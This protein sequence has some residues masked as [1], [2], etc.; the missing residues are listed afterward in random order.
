[1][2]KSEVIFFAIFLFVV[3]FSQFRSV[4]QALDEAKALNISQIVWVTHAQFLNLQQLC[5]TP[6][7]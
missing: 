2:L 7:R 4:L 1:M 6:T 3:K 5:C